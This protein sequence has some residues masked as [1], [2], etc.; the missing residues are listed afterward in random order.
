MTRYFY[1]VFCVFV[2]L[3]V[4]GMSYAATIQVG[5]SYHI[6]S[7]NHALGLV[8][9][10]DTI[11]VHAGVYREGNI[12]IR[13]RVV[14]IGVG[15]PV[16][17]G[18]KQHEPFSVFAPNVT[19]RGFTIKASGRSSIRD[20]AA[21]K[22]YDTRHAT[23]ADNILDDNFFG[24]YMQNAKQ[25]TVRNNQLTAYGETEQLTGNGIHSWKSDSLYIAGNTIVGHRDGIYLEFVT[26]T[27]VRDNHALH[28]R[29]YGLHF[30]FSHD[31]GYYANTF[32]GNGAGVAVM[33]TKHVRMAHNTFNENWG[34]AAYGLLLKDIT[35]SHIEHNVFS[36]N[37]TAILMEGSNRVQMQRNQFEGNGWA[38]KM[39]AS[40]MDNVVTENNFVQ[41]TF[42]V[43]TNG[44][45]V[46]NTF[47]RNYWDKYEG[48]DLDKDHEGDV[49]FRPV[50]LYS[51]VVEKFPMAML[52]FRSFIVMLLDRTER[53][54]PSLTPENLKDDFPL[55]KP[56]DV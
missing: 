53:V 26:R 32:T 40:C 6:K 3:A 55:M 13:K 44:S 21:I 14:L 16:I 46:L 42:D 9:D 4:S 11:R 56:I 10:G 52:L 38:L 15:N 28:N 20:I 30:M 31:N 34:D 12:A 49:P 48:Y 1:V 22:I 39:Q 50:S 8:A 54:I 29:R 17:D 37:T 24:I 41:N 7:I 18:E 45:L 5:A 2:C 27:E 36:R 35:D 51:M 47:A 33:Y 43:A 25:C 23:I 19:I